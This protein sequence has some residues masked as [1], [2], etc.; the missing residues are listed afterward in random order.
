MMLTM[1]ALATI[2]NNGPC[3]DSAKS[4]PQGLFGTD[5][6]SAIVKIDKIVSTASMIEGETIGYL[7]TRQDGSTWLGERAQPYMSAA[8]SRAVNALFASTH[9]PGATIT[10]FPPQRLYGV[11]TNYTQIFQIQ[12]PTQAL[13][14]L[15]IDLVP[16]VAWPAGMTLP[17]PLP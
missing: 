9:M 13:A 1:L 7:Y 17:N 3:L 6:T 12:L 14:P 4:V 16:C 15:Q 8:D 11:K 10:Q 5:P 2:L